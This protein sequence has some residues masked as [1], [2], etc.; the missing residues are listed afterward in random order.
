[1][2]MLTMSVPRVV[3]EFVGSGVIYTRSYPPIGE[4]RVSLSCWLLDYPGEPDDGCW[5]VG[6]EHTARPEPTD[7]CVEAVA[8]RLRF[9]RWLHEADF[10]ARGGRLS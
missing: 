5:M 2:N 4:A 3:A 9:Y 1:M 8:R 6:H 7:T 10:L